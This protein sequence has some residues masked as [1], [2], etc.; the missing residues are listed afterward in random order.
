VCAAP[1]A[2]KAP[3]APEAIAGM[4]GIEPMVMR[5]AERVDMTLGCSVTRT[6]MASVAF[7]SQRGAWAMV[8]TLPSMVPLLVGI[9]GLGNDFFD[10]V[11]APESR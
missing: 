5:M 9:G 1:L 8:V 6:S 7:S 3:P 11:N 4:A 10:T 2:R